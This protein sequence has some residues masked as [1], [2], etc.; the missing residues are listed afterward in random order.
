[1]ELNA[2]LKATRSFPKDFLMEF[3]PEEMTVLFTISE[4]HR[5]LQTE[6]GAFEGWVLIL[7][8][9][10]PRWKITLHIPASKLE[11]LATPRFHRFLYR[12]YQFSNLPY[13]WLSLSDV[14]REESQRFMQL[15][16]AAPKRIGYPRAEPVKNDM[17]RHLLQS[18]FS[19][20]DSI[21]KALAECKDCTFHT[22][23][24]VSVYRATS[25]RDAKNSNMVFP[26][27][28][29]GYVDIWCIHEDTLNIFMLRYQKPTISFISE[30]FFIANCCQDV[31]INPQAQN[32]TFPPLPKTPHRGFEEFYDGKERRP[33]KAIN[34]WFL[35]DTY[36]PRINEAYICDMLST[37]SMHYHCLKYSYD[38]PVSLEEN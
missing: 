34:A 33:L 20:S 13:T 29:G 25:Q 12:V 6:A 11:T 18:K 24:P 15:Y 22:M 38:F 16:T 3:N 32:I 37:S 5:S 17:V 30:M 36:H 35:A 26:Q 28:V 19:A 7:H 1:M 23:L 10:I 14:L 27:N 9:M 8:E 21:L 31:F 4:P 2:L